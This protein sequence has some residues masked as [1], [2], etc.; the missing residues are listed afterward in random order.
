MIETS[1]YRPDTDD[2]ITFAVEASPRAILRDDVGAVDFLRFV[3]LVQ[4]HWVL[5]GEAPTTRSPGLHHNVSNTCTVRPQEWAAAADFIWQN[6]ADFTGI[7]LLGHDG[8]KRYPQAPRETVVSDDDIARWNRLAYAQVDYT[9]LN[10][11]TDETT[12]KDVAACAG[13]KCDLP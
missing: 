12:L 4:R 2:V 6:R 13:G 9:A 3:Q 8:D 5:A 1:V 7:A 11:P 10:E